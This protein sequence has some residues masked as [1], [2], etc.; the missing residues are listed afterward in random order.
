MESGLLERNKIGCDS[1]SKRRAQYV[2]NANIVQRLSK[3]DFP[4][5]PELSPGMREYKT[6]SCSNKSNNG[7]RIRIFSV[8]WSI[9]Q[10]QTDFSLQFERY[11]DNS[12]GKKYITL[13]R[14]RR[15]YAISSFKRAS[16]GLMLSHVQLLSIIKTQA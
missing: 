3:A 13:D 12:S 6:L 10:M 11:W 9:I 8:V 2:M 1:P 15:L 4:P 14:A 7:A 16:R 5:I